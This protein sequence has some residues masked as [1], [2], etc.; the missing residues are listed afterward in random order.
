MSNKFEGEIYMPQIDGTL[1]SRIIA[2]G[3]LG[4]GNLGNIGPRSEREA[5]YAEDLGQ[6]KYEVPASEESHCMDDR[7]EIN[8]IQL[9]GNRAVTEVAGDYMDPGA[10]ELHLSQALAK[11]IK[12]LI[13]QGCPPCFHEGCAALLLLSNQ[14]ALKYMV[15]PD[16]RPVVMALA[17]ARLRVLGVD[18]LSPNDYDNAFDTLSERLD[19]KEL[20]DASPAELMEI[21]KS[22]G[23]KVDPISGEHSA[24]GTRWDMSENAFNNGLFRKEC[25]GDDGGPIGALSVTLGAY[26]KQLERNGY[27]KRDLDQ[28]MLQATLYQVAVLKVAQ[29]EDAPDIIVA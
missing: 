15:D 11:K 29:A 14:E 20:W 13:E 24:V 9:A 16:N 17:D 7:L 6:P 4:A 26:M 8:G 21:A 5:N 3:T 28:K 25:I 19:K 18:S 10:E 2:Q 12:E 27:P 1:E 22:C 23:A